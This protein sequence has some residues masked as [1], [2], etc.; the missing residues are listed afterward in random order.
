MLL[1]ILLLH[2]LDVTPLTLFVFTPV[3][4]AMTP[5]PLHGA[6]NKTLSKPVMICQKRR[7]PALIQS[8]FYIKYMK[9]S[10]SHILKILVTID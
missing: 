3:S 6:S 9:W 4:L 7:N 1:G 10:L 8:T 5:V 2:V